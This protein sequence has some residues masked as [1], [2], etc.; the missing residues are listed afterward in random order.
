MEPPPKFIRLKEN[1]L[2]FRYSKYVWRFIFCL[3]PPWSFSAVS[4]L[5]NLNR[6]TWNP[7]HWIHRGR[8]SLWNTPLCW[9]W[10]GV[11]KSPFF[12]LFGT[13]VVYKLNRDGAN[14]RV[15]APSKSLLWLTNA[16]SFFTLNDCLTCLEFLFTKQAYEWAWFAIMT[17]MVRKYN[18]SS[19]PIS[20]NK[21]DIWVQS[22]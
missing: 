9:V 13:L 20:Q 2:F 12:F 4:S 17:I 18:L 15:S 3:I 14:R 7:N 5:S 22:N 6:K 21:H 11:R 8:I 19:Y 16:P 10:W 1:F